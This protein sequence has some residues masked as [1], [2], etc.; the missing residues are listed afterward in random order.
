MNPTPFDLDNAQRLGELL[1]LVASAVEGGA[2]AVSLDTL[3]GYLTA[4]AVGP[5]VVAPVEAMDALFGQDWPAALEAQE[6]T[7]AFVEA[8]HLRWNEIAESVEPQRLIDE[9]EQMH[10]TPLIAEIDDEAKRALIEQGLITAELAERLPAAGV[11]WA[12]GFLQAA[13]RPEWQ[14]EEDSEAAEQLEVMLQALAALQLPVGSDERA[15]YIAASY[16][17]PEEVDHNTLVDDALFTAQDLRLFWLQQG[18]AADLNGDDD[19]P[20]TH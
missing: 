17:Q 6:Q 3:D 16:E 8:L 12:D 13:Q 9:P 11:M 10:L 14:L 7:E 15:Q 19:E 18:L 2:P 20:A 1:A 5:D 4:L